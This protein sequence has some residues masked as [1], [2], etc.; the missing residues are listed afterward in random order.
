MARKEQ[1]ERSRA[2]L[3]AAARL[4]FTELGYDDTTVAGILDRAG[5]A[6]GALYHYFPGG[7]SEI[8]AAVFDLVDAE[9][10]Q[11][12]D[13]MLRLP[14]ALERLKGGAAVFLECC[15][16]DS[17]ARIALADGP[18]LV[19]GQR[20]LGSSYRLLR[21]QLAEAVANEEAPPVDVDATAMAVYGAIRSAGEYV[22][23]SPDR[24][25]AASTAIRTISAL[26]G[27]LQLSHERGGR[28][29]RSA[30]TG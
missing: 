6:R 11:R 12:R 4:C 25:T 24:A 30:R 3:L 13:A 17:F 5:M 26:I 9:Y 22:V 20:G 19:P 8:F 21:E 16:D 10:H 27:G 28:R 18:R 2:E 7:K 29:D 14:S 23:D 15:T 1:A